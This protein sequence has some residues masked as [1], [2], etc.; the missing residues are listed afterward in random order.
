M[1]NQCAA[2]RFGHPNAFEL[3]WLSEGTDM[4]IKDVRL[5]QDL[6][7]A[8]DPVKNLNEACVVLVEGT[9]DDTTL[10]GRELDSFAIG[11]W[12]SAP[13]DDVEPSKRTDTIDAVWITFGLEIRRL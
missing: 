7:D 8:L 12:R 9:Q 2:R 11:L 4:L 5:V 10:Q 3:V 6:L 13:L 1:V